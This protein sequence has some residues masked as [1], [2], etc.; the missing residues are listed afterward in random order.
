MIMSEVHQTESKTRS[1]LKGLTWRVLATL[2]TFCLAWLFAKDL[3][4]AGTIATAEFFIKFGIYYLHERAWQT[5]PRGTIKN[6]L[7]KS[8]HQQI[9]A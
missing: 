4:V 5:V 9:S 1:V 6:V 3:S 2:T 7:T 8:E